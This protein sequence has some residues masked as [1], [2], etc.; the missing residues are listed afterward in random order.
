MAQIDKLF[1]LPSILVLQASYG[2][3]EILSAELR[4]RCSVGSMFWPLGL[5]WCERGPSPAF[6]PAIRVTPS[7]VVPATPS[8]VVPAEPRA[9]ALATP[10]AVAAASF[11]ASEIVDPRLK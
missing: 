11:A 4:R 1:N 3:L 6:R 9:V 10:P 5:S 2:L 7:A 8:A